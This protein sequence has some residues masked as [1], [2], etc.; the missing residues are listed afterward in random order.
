M[1]IFDMIFVEFIEEIVVDMGNNFC[2]IVIQVIKL[3]QCILVDYRAISPAILIK[4][5]VNIF[6]SI[7][8]TSIVQMQNPIDI[9]AK[10]DLFDMLDNRI[11]GVA[12][13]EM[14]EFAIHIAVDSAI[15]FENTMLVEIGDNPNTST[16]DFVMFDENRSGIKSTRLIALYPSDKQ[17]CGLGVGVRF[18]FVEIEINRTCTQIHHKQTK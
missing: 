18:H 3:K 12:F 14:C 7:K 6:L 11:F 2:D 16:K 4:K 5:I 1:G 15:I 17:E 8:S 10:N 13:V 9:F